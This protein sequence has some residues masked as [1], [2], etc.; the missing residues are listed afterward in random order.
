MKTKFIL[1]LLYSFCFGTSL[2]AQNKRPIIKDFL[3]KEIIIEDNFAGQSITLIKENK[4]YFILR[5]FFGSGVPVTDSIKYKV[6]FNSDYQICFSGMEGKKTIK[7][8]KE[9]FLLG[10]DERG[11]C[12]FLNGLR[13][14]INDEFTKQ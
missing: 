7:T 8:N 4:D 1:I 13:V 14:V 2:I 5:K 9:E 11:L 12:L 10:L 6:T 3:N